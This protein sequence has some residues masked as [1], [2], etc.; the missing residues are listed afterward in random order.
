[1][2]QERIEDTAHTRSIINA[3]FEISEVETC[4]P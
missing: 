3:D 2:F 1:M 4:N